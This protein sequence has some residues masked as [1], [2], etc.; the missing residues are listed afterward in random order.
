MNQRVFN[1]A[2]A[3][4]LIMIALIACQPAPVVNVSPTPVTFPATYSLIKV[5]GDAQTGK[6]TEAFAAKLKIKAVND[7]GEGVPNVS[8]HAITDP[9]FCTL[10]TTS[11]TT[12]PDGSA[13]I[14][15]TAGSLGNITCSSSVNVN[16]T[17]ASNASVSFSSFVRPL[18]RALS[19]PATPALPSL[20]AII[21]EPPALSFP[22]LGSA[23]LPPVDADHAY[24]VYLATLDANGNVTSG[25]LKF[26]GKIAG[27]PLAYT[28][29]TPLP[30]NFLNANAIVL[31]L[32]GVNT[33]SGTVTNSSFVNSNVLAAR[34]TPLTAPGS[35]NTTMSI[36]G[37]GLNGA[38]EPYALPT[39]LAGLMSLS[40]SSVNN[41]L[42]S[43]TLNLT[44]T[45]LETSSPNYRF[46]T[47]RTDAAGQTV[48]IRTV[49]IDAS[50]STTSFSVS[51]P[52]LSNATNP[53]TIA[54]RRAEFSRVFVTLEPV[55]VTDKSFPSSSP[56]PVVV[57][58]TGTGG[59]WQNIRR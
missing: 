44:I 57:L 4:G 29:A 2:T 20:N 54:D 8:L 3:S 42:A 15:L 37:T 17:S 38:L 24:G 52:P 47:Y 41:G 58:D 25:S 51:L 23:N 5:S 11:L 16:G 43:D 55:A 30:A 22:N 31:V 35:S 45:G 21:T 33:P 40:N 32:Y 12:G 53:T 10:E 6:A 1:A 46:V 34:F 26:A 7:K 49:T 56:S 27:T 48:R 18:Q 50:T 36:P 39:N 9:R 19:R 14:G 28:P 59:S 13:E